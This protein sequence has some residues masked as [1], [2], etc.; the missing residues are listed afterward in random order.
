MVSAIRVQNLGKRYRVNQTEQLGDYQTLR[1][2]LTGLAA[3]P[4]RWWRRRAERRKPPGAA[5]RPKEFWALRDVNFEIEPGEV[6]GIIGRNGAGKS[7]LLKI[8]SRITR[9]TSGQVELRGRVGS[10][11]EVGTGFH[12]ELTGRENIYLNGSILGMRRQEINHKLGAIIE[13][14]ELES[15]IDTPVKRYSTGMYVRLAFS[16]AAHINPEILL[17]DEVLAV[18]DIAFQK[19]CLGQMD[20]VARGGRTVIFVSHQLEALANLCPTSLLM[21]NGRL[22][23]QEDTNRVIDRYIAAQQKLMSMR[24][25]ERTDH[26]GYQR[27]RFTDTWV[28]DLQGQR[29]PSVM[30]GQAVK[31]VACYEIA[32]GQRVRRPGISFAVYTQRGAPVT[33]LFSGVTGPE[34]FGDDLPARGRFECLIPRLPLNAGCYVYNV[35][36]ETGPESEAEDLIFG[37]G[38][39]TVEHGDFFATGKVIE[40]KFPM[41]TDHSW[42]LSTE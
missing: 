39:F 18:G 23:A 24:L 29:L 33:R 14:A 35:M 31:L 26:I 34:E 5:R 32:P 10:L 21:E 8:L 4:L 16:V 36:A 20:A 28:E 7:T 38:S 1:E 30:S 17:V 37:A 6:V 41:L 19:K 11:L 40:P 42:Q 2:T 9:P 13:F 25:G 27:L 15:F 3:A 12:P 22:T